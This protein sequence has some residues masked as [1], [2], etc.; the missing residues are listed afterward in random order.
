MKSRS[1]TLILG[2]IIALIV[3]F[4][5]MN[6]PQ[7]IQRSKSE[8]ASMPTTGLQALFS[9]TIDLSYHFIKSINAGK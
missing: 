2:I 8:M 5:L 6:A 3:G 1:V 7:Q 9:K 4:L